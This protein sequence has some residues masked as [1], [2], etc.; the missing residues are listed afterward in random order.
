MRARAAAVALDLALPL[1]AGIVVGISFIE[2]P[3]KFQ[4][5]SLTTAV[6]LD[7]GRH[8]FAASHLVQ[9]GLAVVVAL[10]ARWAGWSRARATLIAGAIAALLV[11]MALVMPVLDARARLIIAGGTPG[12]SSAHL[13]YVGL[14]LA[15]LGLLIAAAVAARQATG[16]RPLRARISRT[17]AA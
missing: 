8:V 7:V 16:A 1:W 4:A 12:G 9:L 2:A 6:G 5:P 13:I 11:Q 17:S 3:V 10:A 15:K 14:E